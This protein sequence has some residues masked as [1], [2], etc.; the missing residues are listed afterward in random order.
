M[1]RMVKLI[2]DHK[3]N[4]I[5]RTQRSKLGGIHV[6]HLVKIYIVFGYNPQVLVLRDQDGVK[7]VYLPRGDLRESLEPSISLLGP[8]EDEKS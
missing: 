7:P 1:I 8:R 5:F 3:I 4:I 2:L 6:S